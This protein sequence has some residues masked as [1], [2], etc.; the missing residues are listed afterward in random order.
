MKNI[1]LFFSLVC[2]SL[3]LL[4]SDFAIL[5]SQGKL[6]HYNFTSGSSVGVTN[7]P[8]NYS[9]SITIPSTV[10]YNNNVYSVSSIEDYAFQNC[11][12]LSSITIPNSILN[13][14]AYAFSNCSS[15]SVVS[16][17]VCKDRVI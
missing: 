16:Q 14:G 9:G 13:I 12:N 2:L 10:T 11:T 3:N 15:L 5:N 6:I 8:N 7:D 17:K 1:Y 4:A